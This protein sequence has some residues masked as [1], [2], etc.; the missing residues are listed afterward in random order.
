MG[1]EA[2]KMGDH[3]LIPSGDL[4]KNMIII[5]TIILL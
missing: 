5:I 3:S 2:S 1:K 4:K